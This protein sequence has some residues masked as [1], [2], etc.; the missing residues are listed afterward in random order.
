MWASLGSK[1]ASRWLGLWRIL[2]NDASS[3]PMCLL[4][5]RKRDKHSCRVCLV[6]VKRYKLLT[7]LESEH[8][9]KSAWSVKFELIQSAVGRLNLIKLVNRRPWLDGRLS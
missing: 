3:N 6:Y 9:E 1:G 4:P 7:H 8:E 2:R 5:L